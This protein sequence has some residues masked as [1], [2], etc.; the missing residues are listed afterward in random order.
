MITLLSS[1]TA[2]PFEVEQ[3]PPKIIPMCAL[4]TTEPYYNCDSIW[5]IF[6]IYGEI[7]V[8][9]GTNTGGCAYGFWDIIFIEDDENLGEDACGRTSLQHELL[10]LKYK[11]DSI[12]DYDKCV[13]W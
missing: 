5:L 13:M 6:Y 4:T 12:H 11:D 3:K 2:I 9:C 7:D 10:H 8:I 1:S